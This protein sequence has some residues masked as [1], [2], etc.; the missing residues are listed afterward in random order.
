MSLVKIVCAKCGSDDVCRDAA[1]RWDVRSQEW[2]VSGVHDG[3]TCEV[4]DDQDAKLIEQPLTPEESDA[5][6]SITSETADVFINR[7]Q[8]KDG[9]SLAVYSNNPV[10]LGTVILREVQPGLTM[11]AVESTVTQINERA[12]VWLPY[13]DDTGV[14]TKAF[15]EEFVL[16]NT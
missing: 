10:L 5:L 13:L 1:A 3:A 2:L 16:K 4:C 11:V 14:T 7:E 6:G 9:I 12:D 8:H 15:L